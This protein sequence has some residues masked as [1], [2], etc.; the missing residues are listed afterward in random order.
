MSNLFDDFDLFSDDFGQED[1]S[2][3]NTEILPV[4]RPK[5]PEMQPISNN[6]D[7][8]R[9]FQLSPKVSSN[10]KFSGTRQNGSKSVP[11]FLTK[12]RSM[13]DRRSPAIQWGNVPGTIIIDQNEM[14]YFF[15]YFKTNKIASL[16]RSLNMYG[17]HKVSFI[18]YHEKNNIFGIFFS[19][20]MYSIFFSNMHNFLLTLQF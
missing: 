4:S 5:T 3:P 2:A 12:L 10:V 15:Q 7:F 19:K 6:Q 20:E 14:D 9:M 11:A 13:L 17:F 16:T 1:L 18:K 8:D